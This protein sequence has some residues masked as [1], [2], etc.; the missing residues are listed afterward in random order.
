MSNELKLMVGDWVNVLISPTESKSVQVGIVDLECIER[1]DTDYSPIILT[2]DIMGN[3]NG[4]EKYGINHDYRL[5]HIRI[6]LCLNNRFRWV[7]NVYDLLEDEPIIEYLH[8]LQQLIRLFTGKE[9][10]V[11]WGK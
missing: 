8:Q 9:I 11:K 10:E 2:L 6:C 3:I 7:T 1:G 5:G 4:M